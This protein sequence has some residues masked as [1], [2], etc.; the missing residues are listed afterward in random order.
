MAK[1]GPKSAV[2]DAEI[3]ARIVAGKNDSEIARAFHIGRTRVAR[4]RNLSNGLNC[5]SIDSPIETIKAVCRLELN[6]EETRNEFADQL[7]EYTKNYK[8]AL[9][10]NDIDAATKWSALRVRLL[11]NMVKISGIDRMRDDT[12]QSAQQLLSN[13]SDEEVRERARAILAKH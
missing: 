4:V 3:A 13:M 12:G 10:E 7:Y 11:E 9:L 2:T 8:R 6:Q 5:V 1:R